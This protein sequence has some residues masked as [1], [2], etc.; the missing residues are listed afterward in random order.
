MLIFHL[1][2]KLERIEYGIQSLVSN[3]DL[4]MLRNLTEDEEKVHEDCGSLSRQEVQ[5]VTHLLM[6]K[7]NIQRQY[8]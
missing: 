4:W 1:R 7:C 5:V 6:N 8:E 2:V 3:N